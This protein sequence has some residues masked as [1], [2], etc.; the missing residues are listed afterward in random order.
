MERKKLK[1]LHVI[2]YHPSPSAFIFAKR[3]V[4]DLTELGHSNE[5]FYFN[6]AF[7]ILG[8]FGQLKSLKKKVAA[9][10]PDIIHAHYGT[11]NAFF[12][13]RITNVPLVVSFHGS[14]I[15]F[16]RDVHWL[17]EKLGKLLSAKA[18]KCANQIICVSEKLQDNL[19][20][21]KEKSTVLASGINTRMFRRIDMEDCKEKLH[22]DS[23]KNYVFFNSSNPVVKRLDIAEEVVSQLSDLQVELL[24]LNG[25]VEPNEIPL[26]LNSCVACLLCSDSEGSPMVIKES[27]A[28]ELPVVS[29][30]VGDVH[31][32]VQGVTNS[33]IV[34][35][36]ATEIAKK[37]RLLISLNNPKTNGLEVLREQGL[38]Y[39]SV[40]NQLENIYFK[41]MQSFK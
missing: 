27:M 24:S 18:A 32:R 20:T 2:P 25:N 38:D 15:N 13:S 23:K 40:A 10:S 1:I 30:D 5:I 36:D 33:Y 29:V 12:A 21:G 34:P 3:Q 26:Y 9:F 19:P 8:F 4:E 39:L 16:T 17:R 41:A 28:C 31:E 6:T 11:I 22:L 14:D 35:Q 37:I 7:S